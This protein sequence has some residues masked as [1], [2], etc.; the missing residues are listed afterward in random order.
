MR[1]LP[2]LPLSAAT[3]IACAGNAPRPA[4]EPGAATPA[5][6]PPVS[7]PAPTN[8][9]QPAGRP[10][11]AEPYQGYGN[12]KALDIHRIGQWTHTGIAERR[13][14]VVHDSA[15]W[16][17]VRSELAVPDLPEVDF[18]RNSVVVVAAGQQRSGGFGIEVERVSQ[19]GGDLTIR[20]VETS[21]GRNCVTTSEL[22]Q[23]VDVVT[24]PVTDVQNWIFVEGKSAPDCR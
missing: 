13:R 2:L 5:A 7:A 15:A 23:P 16:A 22:T 9:P 24:V 10:T 19:K 3:L 21:P 18:A 4:E 8:P 6:K 12:G 1:R 17:Q 11:P 14:Q 20:V